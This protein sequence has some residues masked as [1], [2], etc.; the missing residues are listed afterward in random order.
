MP[1][2]EGLHRGRSDPLLTCDSAQTTR[3]TRF[4]GI[5]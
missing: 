5:L 3:R 2:D 1:A 4:A